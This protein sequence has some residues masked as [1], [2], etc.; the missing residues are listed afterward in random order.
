MDESKVL[1]AAV[2]YKEACEKLEELTARR[3]ELWEQLNDMDAVTAKLTA[4]MEARG[5]EL[6]EACRGR[7]N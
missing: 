1:V 2:A 3:R 5:K 4:D 6:V 7:S